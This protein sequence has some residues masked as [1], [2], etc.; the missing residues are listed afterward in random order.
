MVSVCAG[1]N[2]VA[3]VPS[4]EGLKDPGVNLYQISGHNMEHVTLGIICVEIKTKVRRN[5][6]TKSAE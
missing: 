2:D 3:D 5:K 4:H 6:K 1:F